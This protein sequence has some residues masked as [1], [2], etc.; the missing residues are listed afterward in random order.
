[1]TWMCALFTK[2]D[3]CNLFI[4][5][6][7]ELW[8]CIRTIYEMVSHPYFMCSQTKNHMINSMYYRSRSLWRSFWNERRNRNQEPIIKTADG[9]GWKTN[10]ANEIPISMGLLNAM[11][12]FLQRSQMWDF[13]GFNHFQHFYFIEQIINDVNESRM[14]NWNN[15]FMPITGCNCQQFNAMQWTYEAHEIDV[16]RKYFPSNLFVLV[17]TKAM[18]RTSNW[19]NFCENSM[20]IELE[21]SKL[22][23]AQLWRELHRFFVVSFILRKKRQRKTSEKNAYGMQNLCELRAM[24]TIGCVHENALAFLICNGRNVNNGSKSHYNWVPPS[25]SKLKCST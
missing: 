5:P 13:Y 21:C 2:L 25:N 24:H 22:S 10:V 14:G 15:L 6:P 8:K 23:D 12:D 18:R 3:K 9:F 20:K 19:M 4:N 16:Q 11:N 17:L 7:T 1:M